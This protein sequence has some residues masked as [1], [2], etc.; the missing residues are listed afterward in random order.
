[1]LCIALLC[2]CLE[3]MAAKTQLPRDAFH[4]LLW[5]SDQSVERPKGREAESQREMLGHLQ[6]AESFSTWDV[7]GTLTRKVERRYRVI[8]VEICWN[9]GNKLNGTNAQSHCFVFFEVL[10]IP[11]ASL[12][13]ADKPSAFWVRPSPQKASINSSRHWNSYCRWRK[14]GILWFTAL[15]CL[16]TQPFL[17]GFR[18]SPSVRLLAILLQYSPFSSHHHLFFMFVWCETGTKLWINFASFKRC[19]CWAVATCKEKASGKTWKKHIAAVLE[20]RSNW[21]TSLPLVRSQGVFGTMRAP[22]ITTTMRALLNHHMRCVFI[23]VR[24]ECLKALPNWTCH[25]AQCH[26]MSCHVMPGI[27]TVFNIVD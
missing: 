24:M 13:R 3:S 25:I 9:S 21:I 6:G 26:I 20:I 14:Q 27:C 8:D 15:I 18:F 22:R 10:L 7:P 5:Q 1:M 23:N 4:R 2:L 16:Q 17:P 19:S 12:C 11:T